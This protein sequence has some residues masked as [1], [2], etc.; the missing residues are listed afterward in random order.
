MDVVKSVRG[1]LAVWGKGGEAECRNML[2]SP[3][4]NPSDPSCMDVL[5]T[6]YHT[7]LLSVLTTWSPKNSLAPQAL[8]TFVQS[9]LNALPSSSSPSQSIKS[10]H[11]A[12]FGEIL[13]DIVWSIDTQ[14]DEL[15]ADAKVAVTVA[16]QLADRSLVPNKTSKAK[17]NVEKDKE[18]LC[19]L[20]K[21]FL[22]F[23]IL[24]S[25]V[26][27]ERLDLALLANVGLISDRSTFDKKEI[28]TRT[29]LFYKQ[30]KFNLL[31]EQSEGYSKL[32]VELTSSLGP[33]HSPLDACPVESYSSIEE[34]ARQVWEKV[35]SLIGYFDLDPNRALD[36]ILDVLSINLPTHYTFFLALLSFSPWSGSYRRPIEGKEN[37]AMSIDL[38]PGKYQGKNL[39]EVLQIAESSSMGENFVPSVYEAGNNSRVLAQVLGFKFAYYQLPESGDSHPKQLYLT[40]AVLICENIITLEDLYPHMAPSD[41]DMEIFHKDYLAEVQNRI[42]GAKVSQLAMAAPLESASGTRPRPATPVEVKKTPEFKAPNQKAGLLSALLAVGALRPA[43]AIITKFPW[44]V[45][46]HPEIADLVLRVLKLSISTVYD[47]TFVLKERNAS[48][49]QPR[50]RYGSS[51]TST[52]PSR[53]PQLTLTAPTP[54]STATTDFVFFFPDWSQSV[55]L[56]Q[57]LDDLVDVIEPLMSFIGLHI[58]RDPLFVTKFTRLGRSQ[59]MSIIPL[60]PVTKRPSGDA[61]PSHPIRL[62]WFKVLRLYLLPALPLIRG[63]AVCT[64]EIWNIIRQYE[65]TARWR[66]YGEWKSSTYKS[67]PELRIRQV[68][69]DR[70]SKGILRRLSH[71]TIDTLSGTVAKL[72][73]SNPCIFFTNAVNQI[74]AYDNLAN[75]VIQA[76]RYVTNMGFDV[77]VYI[78]LDALSNPN[79]DRVKDDGV[80]TSDW[81]QSLASF[82]GMLFRRYSA[83]LTPVLKYIVHQLYNGQATDI[84]VLRE[85]IWKMA[86]IEPLPSLSDAQI[87]AMAG[88]PALRIEAV[89]S[90]TRGARLDPGDAVLKGPQRLGKALLDS[91][92]ALPLLIQVAQQRQSCVFKAPNAHLKSL[93]S[94]FDTTHGVLLQYL[95]LLTSP[96][97][98]SPQDYANKVLPSLANLG[99]T[100]GISAPMCM[101]IIRPML[102]T[103][104]LNAALSMQEKERLAN[105][106]AEKR[107]KAR[108][109]AK[110]EPS[111]ATSRVAS[112][113]GGSQSTPD[114]TATSKPIVSEN[115]G[116]DVNMENEISTTGSLPMTESPWIPE[117]A[118]LFEDI[119]KVGRTSALD[120]IGPGFYITFWQL[121]TY[122]LA[123]PAARYD[124]E[125][126]ALRTL[127]RQEDSKYTAADRSADRTKRQMASSHR[128]KRD[129]YNTF[130][131]TLAQEFKEQAAS[132]VFT[133]KRL[134]REKQ[135]WF[136]HN[137]RAAVL[138]SAVIEHCIQPRCLLSPM[139]ADYCAQIIK[140][141]HTQGT[142]GFPTLVCY[143]KLLGDH[144]KAIVF[145]CSEYEA[146]NYGRFLL[147]ILS[148]LWK[149]AQEEPLFVQDN[150][151]K[152]GGKTILLP[153]FQHRWSNKTTITQEDLLSWGGFKQILRKW[154][155]KLGRSLLSC[156]ETGE[157]MH[158]YNAIIVLKEILPVFP[159]ATVSDAG[160]AI[161]NVM[162]KFLEKEERGDLKI[163]GRAYAASLKKRE[164][165]W[166]VPKPVVAKVRPNGLPMSPKP[167]SPAVLSSEKPRPSSATTNGTST[168]S[169]SSASRPQTLPVSSQGP[170]DKHST[171]PNTGTSKFAME[172]I[173][174]PEKVKRVRTEKSSESP[175]PDTDSKTTSAM[176]IDNVTA[177]KE[178][179]PEGGASRSPINPMLHGS[180]DSSTSNDTGRP[181]KST[182]L[183][184]PSTSKDMSPS[185]RTPAEPPQTMPPPS[186]PSQ[187]LSA[188]ELRET[189]KQ[190]ISLRPPDRVDEKREPRSQT[191]SAAPSP[192]HRRR[193]PS[194]ASRP[195][196]RNASVE[197]RA[198]GGR[199]RS[200]RGSRDSDRLDDRYPDRDTHQEPRGHADM[201]H[202][203][204]VTHGRSERST[205]DRVSARD[206]E[207]EADR[208]RDRGRDRHGDRERDKDRDRDRERD[209]DKDKDKDRERRD[210]D[211]DRDRERD[212]DRHRRDD[213][214]RD[215]DSRK[216]REASTRNIPLSSSTAAPDSRSLPT[217]PDPS[218]HRS[219]QNGDDGLGKRRR[220][221][222]DEVRA[223]RGSKRSSRK[224]SHRDDRPRRP[225]EKD[226]HDRPRESDRRRTERGTSEADARGQSSERTTEKR[227]PEGPRD[228]P[229]STPSAPR[230]MSSVDASR[231]TKVELPASRSAD[232][233]SQREHGPQAFNTPSGAGASPDTAPQGPVSLRS[234][235]SDKEG[236]RSLPQ[237]P[238][239]PYRSDPPHKDDDRDNRKRTLSDRDK[240][241]GEAT[242]GAADL[243]TQP[244]KRPRINRNRY[245]SHPSNTS[246]LAR[247]LLPIDPHAGDKT[248]TT[249]KD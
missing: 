104:L 222:D 86:G 223:D 219:A 115:V 64:V 30:N 94:L 191:G 163:L 93:A 183:A 182:P 53:K 87:T 14:L 61:D 57:S 67:H 131:N 137:S 19:D 10:S 164:A 113:N 168:A 240:D 160:P 145:S 227:I 68:Q 110:R 28:R 40:A 5:S 245:T 114:D 143:D 142:P 161:D 146:K 165:L 228:L 169:A 51:K 119:K 158:V 130:V 141:I 54:P 75:V 42:A 6:A 96:A 197:S 184:A 33:S 132:R 192:S 73:H 155:R 148:D 153:G 85:L 125:G 39:D 144:V 174:R 175:V 242:S 206:S 167:A 157:F 105:E 46:A 207:R 154:H 97:V 8:V 217:R 193:S 100:Y 9:V 48:F 101:Q 29:G 99:E 138:A 98:I 233:K 25:S 91:S 38:V 136:A 134:A 203:D 36:I 147:G 44:L 238:I 179:R 123:P 55:P 41:E 126:A 150:R 231:G 16:E 21:R 17:Q 225:S 173:P 220:P 49:T 171:I 202:R 59:L 112:P 230:A 18:T 239:G 186:A 236:S 35:I 71:N 4:C 140:V 221:T 122:D 201:R 212:R 118:A 185:P 107:L 76:L 249:R 224:D 210:R 11:A 7:L 199:D 135:H 133:M 47:S 50:T 166:A 121:S 195:G 196:T 129:R 208:E 234:R 243:T 120:I 246:A 181:S 27:R 190:S 80:N 81:L 189:A 216:E 89:A 124:E 12:L 188:Q 139:D 13:V 232:W 178:K 156:I 149:W 79:K 106:E 74:M 84:V 34:R 194:P 2:T 128:A 31:R 111:T 63:N 176:D 209:R 109:A 103:I 162:E 247:K 108:L 214:D 200:D 15:H 20:V 205:R 72:A 1:Y 65:T 151:I 170:G 241:V 78:I 218:R 235:I 88:G 244:P 3:H 22:S 58:S 90:T 215:R 152:S 237:T 32:T 26:C 102:N 62:F 37:G 226:S 70:E 56:C 52:G 180:K 204:N 116:E 66:L 177:A 83:D 172:N 211:R 229:P 45:D 127:S 60:D 248:R 43:F 213:K 24:D 117:L 95:E 159:L 77:L 23:G 82:T 69:A 187:T 198:S 92:L